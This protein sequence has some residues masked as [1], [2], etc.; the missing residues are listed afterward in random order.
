M[1]KLDF[2]IYVREILIENKIKILVK[3]CLTLFICQIR[4]IY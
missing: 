1:A 3:Y 2:Q 4:F